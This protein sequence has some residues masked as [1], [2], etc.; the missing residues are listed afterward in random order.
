MSKS[1]SFRARE[2]DAG[3][4]LDA[5]LAGHGAYASRSAAAKACESG[6]VFVNGK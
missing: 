2:R 3:N 6:Q 1:F 4:R 5:V